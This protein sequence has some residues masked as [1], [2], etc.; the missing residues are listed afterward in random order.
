MLLLRLER[1][2]LERLLGKAG[3]PCP[4]GDAEGFEVLD[5]ARTAAGFYAVLRCT[6]A[7]MPLLQCQELSLDFT[8]RPLS[9]GGYFVCWIEPDATLCLEAV[10]NRQGWPE[11]F[12]LDDLHCKP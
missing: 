3:M 6:M 4:G 7:S 12:A 10:A 11:E 9:H 8:H 5:R 1:F 2:A